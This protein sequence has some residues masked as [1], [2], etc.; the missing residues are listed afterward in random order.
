MTSVLEGMRVVLF[1]S[2][3]RLDGSRGGEESPNVTHVT[4]ADGS[5]TL[6]GRT[7]WECSESAV[8]NY[9]G[10]GDHHDPAC[11]RCAASLARILKVSP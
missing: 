8:E 2:A 4:R 11:L 1:A 5:R 9:H 7:G 3:F 6:C 10:P